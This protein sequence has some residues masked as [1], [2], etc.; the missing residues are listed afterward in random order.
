MPCILSQGDFS[1]LMEIMFKTIVRAVMHESY[2]FCIAQ[3]LD[4]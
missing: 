2:D 3:Y 1:V 4:N